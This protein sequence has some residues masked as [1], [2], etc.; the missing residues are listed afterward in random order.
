VTD[1]DIRR[2]LLAGLT[3][4]CEVANVTHR[5]FKWLNDGQTDI[6]LL[7]ECREKGI[8]VIPV[9][10]SEKRLVDI[11]NLSERR[12]ILPI[13]AILMAGGKGER[14]RPLTNDTPK[15]LLEIDGKAII[16]YN[17]EALSACG[18]TDITVCTRYLSEKIYKHFAEPVAGVQVKC[19]R[20]ET[21]LGTIGAASLV[22]RPDCGDSLVMNSDLLTSISFEDLYLRHK[23]EE[24]DITVAVI[25]Y[26]V[27][28]PY[29]I[30]TTDGCQVTGIEEKP[31]YSYYANAGIYLISNR[32]LNKLIPDTHIDATDFIQQAVA[33]GRKVIFFPVNG[34]WIDVG[35]PV[36]FRQATEIMRHHRNMSDNN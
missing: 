36:D 29:A 8:K 4:D 11:I 24:A 10:D 13:S 20:E 12:T 9:L 28:V 31:S 21:P 6:T 17:I 22:S 34:T 27:S 18:I 1:G 2:A 16:D 33:D 14:L 30:L 15:P 19:V 25:P 23:G 3:T 7:R 5:S 26:Q 35:S 32:L